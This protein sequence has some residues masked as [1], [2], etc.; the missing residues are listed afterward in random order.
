MEDT[1]GG[2]PVASIRDAVKDSPTTLVQVAEELGVSYQ[3][4]MNQVT[5][6][7]MSLERAAVIA[8]L[9]G[10]D[11]ALVPKGA[12]LPKDSRVLA[13]PGEVAPRGS[14]G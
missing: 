2:H 14:R 13:D 8:R 6:R 9:L 3:S 5:R 11:L 1:R 7:T 12:T 4:L 10:C